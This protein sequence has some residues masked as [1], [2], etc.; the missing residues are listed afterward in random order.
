M[1]GRGGEEEVEEER[2]TVKRRNKLTQLVV[3]GPTTPERTVVVPSVKV[4]VK[5]EVAIEMIEVK[6][7]VKTELQARRG[8]ARRAGGRGEVVEAACTRGGA[9][10]QVATVPTAHPHSHAS[11]SALPAG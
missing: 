9:L 6:A 1:E 3:C 10:P 7:E 8:S 5:T 11:A 4:K 2:W